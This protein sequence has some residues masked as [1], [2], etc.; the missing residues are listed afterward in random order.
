MTLGNID[1]FAPNRM[2][3]GEMRTLEVPQALDVGEKH[4]GDKVQGCSVSEI[5]LH[6]RQDEEAKRSCLW[7]RAEKYFLNL[8]SARNDLLYPIIKIDDR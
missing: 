2:Q 5:P 1:C 4:Q 6:V 8:R 7:R 3:D